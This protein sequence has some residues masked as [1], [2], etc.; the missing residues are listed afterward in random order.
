MNTDTTQPNHNRYLGLL[1]SLEGL[2]NGTAIT[3]LIGSSVI[4]AILFFVGVSLGRG[5]VLLFG[6]VAYVISAIGVSA[7][8]GVLMDSA[9]NISR[10]SMGDAIVVGVVDL[11][12]ILGLTIMGVLAL[13]VYLIVLAIVLFLCKIP[14]L[15]PVLFG[16]LLPILVILSAL[17]V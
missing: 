6:L 3:L 9:R 10:R 2:R 7:A 8:G 11:V 12:K 1:R 5:G 16:L 17:V 4:A 15:G 14:G 13:A